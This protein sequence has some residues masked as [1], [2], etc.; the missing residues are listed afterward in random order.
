V[1]DKVYE[2]KNIKLFQAANHIPLAM[3]E[4][5]MSFQQGWGVE[6]DKAKAA[7]Y[8]DLAAKL[9]DSDAQVALA[10][11]YLRFFLIHAGVME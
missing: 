11:C 7:Y 6:K 9:G 1:T 5:G 4:V 10:E 2:E 8:F 3:Y